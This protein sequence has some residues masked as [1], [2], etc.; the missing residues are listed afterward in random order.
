V[1]AIRAKN[2]MM[3]LQVLLMIASLNN[4]G[5]NANNGPHLAPLMQV[6]H[7]IVVEIHHNAWYYQ[8]DGEE[9]QPKGG[10]APLKDGVHDS[11]PCRMTRFGLKGNV[12][13]PCH[14]ADTTMNPKERYTEQL[15][16]RTGRKAC[17]GGSARGLGQHTTLAK[18]GRFLQGRE[19]TAGNACLNKSSIK[20]IHTIQN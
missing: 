14:N 1:N 16:E 8:S 15:W 18:T 6:M 17:A 20:I 4:C 19:I 13:P 2:T 11:S 5:P 12:P 7:L 10:R 9:Q 3:L